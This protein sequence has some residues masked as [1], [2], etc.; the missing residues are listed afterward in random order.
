MPGMPQ[1]IQPA[2]CAAF[3]KITKACQGNARPAYKLRFA[4]LVDVAKRIVQIYD[5]AADSFVAHQQVG[6]ISNHQDAHVH[7]LRFPQEI[8]QHCHIVRC[9]KEIRGPADLKSGVPAHRLLIGDTAPKGQGFSPKHVNLVHRA[10]PSQNMVSKQVQLQQRVLI[11]LGIFSQIGFKALDTGIDHQL[12]RKIQFF[13]QAQR[14][15][16]AAHTG[17]KMRIRI[18]DNWHRMPLTELHDLHTVFHRAPAVAECRFVEF[19]QLA[20][21]PRL[22]DNALIVIRKLCGTAVPDDLDMRILAMFSHAF[23][24]ASTECGPLGMAGSCIEATIQSKLSTSLS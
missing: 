7:F 16:K 9:D 17:G 4:A 20:V 12:F 11:H 3:C 10:P 18:D 6:A 13:Q 8:G 19:H 24:M 21:V 2:E 15:F 5:S 23:V 14:I 1:Q 22:R